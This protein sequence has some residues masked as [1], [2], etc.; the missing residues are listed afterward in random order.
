MKKFLVLIILIYAGSIFAQGYPFHQV[1]IGGNISCTYIGSSGVF[2][3][4]FRY[5]N[6]PAFS[7]PCG[8]IPYCDNTGFSAACK[9]D[10][11]FAMFACSYSGEL[12][13]G[14]ISND[15]HYTNKDFK[16]YLVKR[17]DNEFNNPDYANWYKMTGYGAPFI[18]VNNNC[19]FEPGIDK[20][21]M[22]DASETAFVCYTD[23]PGNK[24]PG[25]G[26]GG[27]IY[28]PLL[29]AEL[30]F[31]MWTYSVY[32]FEASQFFRYQIINKGNRNWDSTYFAL[33]V[34][35]SEYAYPGVLLGCDT[36]RHLSFAYNYENTNSALGVVVL[37][38]AVNKLTGDTIYLSSFVWDR[39]V[40]GSFCE[41]EVIAN[42]LG[43]YN[44]MKGF[45]SDGTSFL[46]PTKP[47]GGNKYA[48]TK[49]IFYGDPETNTGW[50]PSKGRISNCGGTDTGTIV[51][52]FGN[53]SSNIVMGMGADNF[54]VAP[55]D[56]Q[57]IVY[58]QTIVRGSNPVTRLKSQT[59]KINYIYQNALK[60]YVENFCYREY[61]IYP[62]DFSLE[63]NYPN[64]FN[65]KTLFRFSVPRVADIKI[66]VFDLLGRRVLVP[67]NGEYKP[68]YYEL[69][70]NAED[71][72]SGIYYY[73][74]QV[75][76]KTVSSQVKYGRILKMAL[77]K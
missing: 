39:A 47:L 7:V 55:G 56:T 13:P 11:L 38:G 28:Y 12:R 77:V 58:C 41:W 35:P 36:N 63:Q 31:T 23:A 22:Q 68:G 15:S 14:Y 18:D 76:D 37:K 29:N 44:Y 4:D 64:P 49:F 74:M 69:T 27:G 26:F 20:P 45:K 46:D 51:P 67:V 25:E 30:R 50:T 5:T 33:F 34:A 61:I 10:G 19:I 57:V 62:D 70:I 59:D 43:A 42:P 71:L 8:S 21:G 52:V 6:T 24:S 1:E 75:V 65:T 48:K 17:F 73:R 9:I 16:I 60:N 72:A 53:P 3:R 40:Y 32:P 66:E 2:N 54:T